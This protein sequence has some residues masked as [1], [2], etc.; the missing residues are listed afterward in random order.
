[1]SNKT[2]IT[3]NDIAAALGLS[4]STVSRALQDH[5]HIKA[6]TKIQVVNEAKRLGYQYNAVAAGLRTRK[7]NTIGLI[8][9]RIAR[10]YQSAVITAIQNSLHQQR[11]NLMICQSNESPE[12]ERELV[13]ALFASR[14]GGLIVSATLYTTDFSPF[15]IFAQSGRPL[16]FFDR[17]P[18]S[19]PAHKIQGD[20]YQGGYLA[21]DHLLQQGCR[22]IA[23]IGGA[24]TCTIYR[25]RYEGYCDA[26][27]KY[28]LTPD[29]EIVFFHDL[30]IENA[31]STFDHI[32]T[33]EK[34]VDAIF[35]GNDT[36]ALTLVTHARKRGLQLPD[37]LKIV[38]YSNDPLTEVVVPSVTSVEQH[39]YEVGNQAA[40]LM[41]GLINGY[42]K[43]GKN[44]MS[45]TIPVELV[46]RASS[47]RE[48]DELII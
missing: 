45:V 34:G 16:V 29:E 36:I 26:L 47:K 12:M 1:M 41:L 13:H 40:S 4:R 25:E 22:R 37:D 27:A 42:I 19:Y 38:G 35:A 28:G 8:V 44:Y 43:P 17:T 48:L 11:Y 20:D 24:T 6:E 14:V 39:P 21:T 33:N 30:T 46:Q 9:P 23:H 3:M 15:D 5:P 10:H 18:K 2:E 7:S 31:I 32:L